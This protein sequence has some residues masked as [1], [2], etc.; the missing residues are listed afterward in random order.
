VPQQAE[1][2]FEQETDFYREHVLLLLQMKA[3]L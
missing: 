1:G 3:F 2:L